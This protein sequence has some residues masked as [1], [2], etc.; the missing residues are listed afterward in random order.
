MKLYVGITDH[1]WFRFL[2]T[3]AAVEMN[4]WRPNSTNE[5]RAIV[6]GELFLFKFNEQGAERYFPSD[7]F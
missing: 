6:P 2:R 7:I 3:K 4:F 5:F 1:D